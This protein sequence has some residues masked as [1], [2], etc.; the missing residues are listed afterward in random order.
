MIKKLFLSILVLHFVVSSSL[1]EINCDYHDDGDWWV[2]KKFYYCNVKNQ[3]NIDSPDRAY[4]ESVTGK[5]LRD[6]IF[7]DVE[8]FEADN[9]TIHYFPRG[10][11]NIFKNLKMIDINNGRLK[12]I[13]Q[14][15]LKPFSK[16]VCLELYEN[17]IES[18][19]K[20]LFDYN[21]KLEMVWLSS[22][23]I[24]HVDVNLFDNLVKLTYLSLDANRCIS[25]YAENDTKKVKE[26]I[27]YSKQNCKDM[28]YLKKLF[29]DFMAN[30]DKMEEN[31]E[32]LEIDI[33]ANNAI[34]PDYIKSDDNNYFFLDFFLI[35][36]CGTMVGILGILFYKKFC[37][38]G[39]KV[40]KR[41]A[42]ENRQYS[43]PT[44]V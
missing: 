20:G 43:N 42:F 12:E 27:K 21:P 28:I 6:K 33:L 37:P 5:H 19:E 36:C 15:D 9:L 22:N 31:I 23:K 16:L 10:L 13:H 35:F 1:I 41:V 4:I 17:D 25:E 24:F 2:L 8:G 7:D 44:L 32:N 18:L 29:P 38:D 3:M 14:S 39:F 11:E 26:I 34:H 40:N 30:I